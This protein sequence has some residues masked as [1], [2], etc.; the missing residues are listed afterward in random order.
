MP[1]RIFTVGRVFPGDAAEYIPFR[2]D[3][4]L[5][6]AD[7]IIFTPTFDE[8]ASYESYAGK[9]LISESDSHDLVLDCAHW[10]NEIKT[11]VEAGKVV[12]VT[13]VKPAEVY[14]DT[15]ERTFSGTGRS[16][17]T[18]RQVASASSYDSIPLQIQG[19]VP[20][21]G[22]EISVLDDLGPLAAYWREFGPNSTY[23]IYFESK[24][25]EP[26]F[27]TK[28]REKVIGAL[29]RYKSG[30]ALV[31]L[32][33]VCWDETALTYSRGKSTF[34]RKDGIILG[35]R[36]LSALIAVSDALRREGSR[37]PIP[38]WAEAAEYSLPVEERLRTQAKEVD[39]QIEHLAQL[40]KELQE[41]IKQ[42]AELRTLLFETGKP[43]EA[44][45]LKALGLLGFNAEP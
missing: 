18:T 2:S 5:F 27:G 1:V 3:K 15:G 35:K 23:E 10:R 7:L 37:A 22:T 26:L 36:L 39:G 11:A 14:Y 9:P 19:L 13:L 32:P 21:G 29:A 43:L 20:K 30:G 12:F 42:A 45:V 25:V 31:L 41:Q 28:K 44:V 38:G 40:R 34:W 16:R 6:D 17:I 8:Y 4:S 33:P 24:G